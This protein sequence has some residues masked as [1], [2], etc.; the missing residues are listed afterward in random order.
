MLDIKSVCDLRIFDKRYMISL[1]INKDLKEKIIDYTSWMSIDTP[2]KIR[3]LAI[4]KNF[5][6][7]TFPKCIV[8]DSHV[9]YDKAYNN[10]FSKYCGPICSR[11]HK[12][13]L[14]NDTY[15]KLND[16]EWL[17]NQRIKLKKSYEEIASELNC[18]INPVK[19]ACIQ[20][21]IPMV[22]HNNSEPM[23]LLKLQDKNWLEQIH[24][25]EKKTTEQ[26]AEMIGSSKAT[27]SRWLNY[28]N[29]ETNEPNSYPRK[30]NK[31]SNQHQ[32]LIEY[33]RS[34][35]GND[36]L[37]IND[38]TVLNGKEV[39]LYIPSKKL[40]I[41]YNGVFYHTFRPEQ[42]KPS[43]RKDRNYHLIKTI[44]C[45]KNDIRLIHIYSDDWI[46]K[47][48]IWK[49]ILS[50]I[51]AN[52]QSKFYARKLSINIPSK[53]EKKLFL[54]ENH[55][56]GDDKSNIWFGL[57]ENTE[58]ISLM[59]FCKSRYNKNYTWELSRYCVKLNTICVGGFSKLLK[60]FQ[61]QY[62]G[63]IISYADYS[64]SQGD[65]YIKN[66]FKFIKRNIPSYAYVDFSKN[67]KRMHRSNFTKNKLNIPDDIT[68]KQY[69]EEN[70]YKRIYDCG[71][72][73]FVKSS[74][75]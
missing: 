7:E 33:I 59:T 40:A 23:I 54:N 18:S 2:L 31:I 6:K 3:C 17:Y 5:T 37:L 34:I 1:S 75:L 55:L 73:V 20:Y 46:Y 12:H 42:S 36:N 62:K 25:K 48:N 51:L 50:N 63:D 30:F 32:Q 26:I 68:E 9:T 71:T 22:K 52:E 4:N 29:I 28:H 67:E 8:C 58:L 39:D 69:M 38:R 57:Y 70:G 14:N 19:K 72:L 15:E 10:K 24:C 11:K 44:E 43:L 45:Q 53:T 74:L 61:M 49:S 65:V 56:Q 60:H 21:N 35:V 66:G 16:K 64:R 41:E 47:N 13:R 27:V